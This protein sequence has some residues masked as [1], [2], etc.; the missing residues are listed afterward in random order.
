[1]VSS[2]DHDPS[3]AQRELWQNEQIALSAR[4]SLNDENLDFDPKTLDGLKYIGGVDLSFPENDFEHALACLSILSWPSL[5]VVHTSYL[6]TE[7]H[8]PYIAGYLA[9]RE[10]DPLLKLLKQLQKEHA[11][12]YP[13]VILVDGNGRLHPRTCGIA[14]HLGVLANTPTIGVAKNFLVI[15]DG[16]ELT[17]SHVKQQCRTQLKKRG[18]RLLLQG[19]DT[20]IMY[21]AALRTTDAAPNPIFVSQGHR[22]SLDMA[23][24][25]VLASC[26][27][28]IPEP[29]RRA[30]LDSR[31]YIRQQQ[32]PAIVGY[33]LHLHVTRQS[34]WALGVY[35]TVVFC[36]IVLQLTFASLNR[37]LLYRYRKRSPS[38][39]SARKQ[40]EYPQQQQTRKATKVGLAVVGYREEPMLFAQCL[41]SIQRMEYPDP[42]KIV[43]V[44]DGKDPQD[45]EM[46]AIFEKAFPNNPVVVLPHLLSDQDTNNTMSEI[47][48]TILNNEKPAAAAAAAAT[49]AMPLPS[50]Q[51]SQPQHQQASKA[52]SSSSSSSSN[53]SSSPALYGERVILPTDTR[54]VCY[55]QPHR[56]KR[57]A[58]YTAFRVL[59]AAGCD[60]VMSTDSDTRFD[61]QALIELERA[62]YW[63]PK[64]GAAAGDVRIW[65]SSDSLLSFMSSLRYWM[66]FNIERAAQSFNRCVTCVSGPMGLYRTNVLA[67]VLDDWIKQRFLGMECTY[68][69]DRHLTN[70]VLMRGYR[71][72][73][74]HY[75]FCETETP[76]NFLRW[77]KQQTRW[78]KSF[79]R[80]LIWNA[81][82]LHKHSPWMAAE[83]FYQ[84]VYPFVLLFSIFY[85]LWAHAPF[86]LAVW[87]VS[88]MAI[89]CI[90][91]LYSFIVTRSLRFLAF[92]MYSIYYLIGLVPAKLWALVSLWDVGWGT[93][94][95]SAAE[96]KLEN[97]LCLQVKEALPIV[98]WILVIVAGITFNLCV[99]FL[100]PSVNGRPGN[101]NISSNAPNV[102]DPNSIV[103]YP[104][105][106]QQ[107][108]YM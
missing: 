39:V 56:G 96:R 18:D 44:I 38:P 6:E 23:L 87:L 77:F 55:L 26:K 31:A 45:H 79:Y 43:V 86:V 16:A 2:F 51:Q 107:P 94:A 25:I 90:K 99:F 75:A 62:L 34:F 7:L 5:E 50:H 17:M 72:V 60:A 103:F 42:F 91:T 92:P 81:R 15:T 41:E 8:L 1:M 89:A 11:E 101:G 76:I 53:R 63:H 36:F 37:Y 95:R 73:Y 27:F 54:A 93:S 108:P 48:E 59:M 14:C 102:P 10:V 82:C 69:D 3:K 66:A 61:P 33:A 100:N 71:V 52:S 105:Y 85:I 67:Q 12:L 20:H 74:T 80:E 21:G 57:H 58:M 24:R 32:F 49:I 68:G 65:N 70:R 98:L 40:E 78:S 97:V 84:G 13:Q 19:G 83:L 28:R 64:T 104:N 106:A 47:D 30:D 88:L 9:F 35:G 46:A 29:I 4:I 22:V